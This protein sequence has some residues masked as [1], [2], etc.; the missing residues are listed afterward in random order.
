MDR[1]AW[2]S[3]VHRVTQNQTRLKQLSSSNANLKMYGDR[4]KGGK[5]TQTEMQMS[6]K[7][8][9]GRLT[10]SSPGVRTHQ[11]RAVCLCHSHGE[12]VA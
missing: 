2:Q 7:P 5:T 8:R 3:T 1:R 4:D 11:G 6:Q 10:V 9:V 12:H